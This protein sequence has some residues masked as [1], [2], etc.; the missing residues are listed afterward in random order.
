MIGTHGGR[1]IG[2]TYPLNTSGI[3]SGNGLTFDDGNTIDTKGLAGKCGSIA[4]DLSQGILFIV[5]T[6]QKLDGGLAVTP[7]DHPAIHGHDNGVGDIDGINPEIVAES[8]H[9]GDVINI[10]DHAVGTKGPYRLIFHAG[11]DVFS[12]F[13]IIRL[14]TL[15]D[16]AG[17]T[18]FLDPAASGLHMLD[19]FF[20]GNTFD[21]VKSSLPEIFGRQRSGLIENINQNRGSKG[22]QALTSHG[23]IKQN[24]D[25][26]FGGNLEGFLVSIAG[27]GTIGIIHNQGLDT[28]GAHDGTEATATGCPGGMSL[29]ISKLDGRS[30]TQGFTGRT[31][32]HDTGF[33]AVGFQKFFGD[34]VGA[35]AFKIACVFKSHTVLSDFNGTQRRIFGGF[36]FQND[37]QKVEL[38]HL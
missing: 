17:M 38:G 24:F 12:V 16:T 3:V 9:L 10:L 14:G 33:L 37:S 13:V 6:F 2:D 27:T 20:T 5:H 31:N 28:L 22:R 25:P 36:I 1:G 32:N 8:V 21:V 26:T 34:S 4:D 23:M 7:G 11:S 35:H 30:K 18:S 15:D 19:H 29:G